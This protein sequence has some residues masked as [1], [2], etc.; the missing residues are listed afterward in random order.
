MP[1][2]RLTIVRR[3]NGLPCTFYPCIGY[4][5][6]CVAN[7]CHKR[8][9]SYCLCTEIKAN[10]LY[11]SRNSIEKK[12]MFKIQTSFLVSPKSYHIFQTPTNLMFSG[13]YDFLRIANKKAI[14]KSRI[15]YIDLT[16][17]FLIIYLTSHFVSSVSIF[18]RVKDTFFVEV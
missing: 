1:F 3:T 18:L 7:I 5:A 4:Y 8:G 6:L 9:C 12:K 16:F 15:L 17:L 13:Q 10:L 11:N 14:V 2:D